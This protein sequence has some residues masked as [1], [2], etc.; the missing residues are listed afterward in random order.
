MPRNSLGASLM[1][2][3]GELPLDA[4]EQAKKML[5][6]AATHFERSAALRPNNDRALG[7]WGRLLLLR[8]QPADALVKLDAAIAINPKNLDALTDRARALAELKRD[9]QAK[10]AYETA[11]QAAEAQRDTP[12]I[13][14]A[15]IHD[16]LARI[17]V[18]EKRPAD[19]RRHYQRSLELTPNDAS[20]HRE[21]ANFL[22]DQNDLAAAAVELAAALAIQPDYIDAHIDM[23]LLHLR[24]D[25]LAAA[26]LDLERATR[27]VAARGESQVAPELKQR[28]V[29]AV[30]RWSA[31]Y[32]AATQPSTTR[33]A[34]TR[35]TTTTTPTTTA[36]AP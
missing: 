14:I 23:G 36:A 24:V 17:A 33:S 4:V 31:A 34:T 16:A 12:R 10:A 26:R 1:E 9:A 2:A 7:N 25:N 35:A 8:G 11:L 21:F 3:V 18:K 6:E 19:A 29:D 5:D 20:L 27:L 32:E 30:H 15:D 13:K 22:I 28:L